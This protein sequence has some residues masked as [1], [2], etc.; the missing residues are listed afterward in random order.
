[1]IVTSPSIWVV[2]SSI[3]VSLAARALPLASRS[4]LHQSSCFLSAAPSSTISVSIL[5]ISSRT[6]EKGF[7]AS[8]SVST[9]TKC[10]GLSLPQAA[11]SSS[12][13]CLRTE[14]GRLLRTRARCRKLAGPVVPSL[15]ASTLPNV[16][17]A[18]SLFKIAIASEIA[19]SS[20]LRIMFLC[21]YSFAFCSH[22]GVN[23][24]R[25]SSSL[26]FSCSA[27]DSCDFFVASSSSLLPRDVC[28]LL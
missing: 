16:S 1:M 20:L 4:A 11:C 21:S 6:V 25:K 10:S 2:S 9:L 26:A 14:R 5:P 24:A 22:M 19:A 15:V 28:F 23:S 27:L 3:S 12:C 8:S 7:S 13:T 18:E 17:K